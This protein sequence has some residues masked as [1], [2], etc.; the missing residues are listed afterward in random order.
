MLKL[1]LYLGL[2]PEL[3]KDARKTAVVVR[4][5]YGLKSAG[6]HFRRATLVDAWN[7]WGISLVRLTWFH[8]LN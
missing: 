3:G 4:A 6:A 8:G 2:G 5:L 7:P 1:S